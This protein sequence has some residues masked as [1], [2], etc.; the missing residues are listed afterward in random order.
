MFKTEFTQGLIN[1]KQTLWDAG[2]TGTAKVE[3]VQKERNNVKT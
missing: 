1:N 2:H 3:L